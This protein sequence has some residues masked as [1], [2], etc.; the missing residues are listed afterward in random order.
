MLEAT[1]ATIEF[2]STSSQDV[3]TDILR[4]GA[5]RLRVR[6]ARHRRISANLSEISPTRSGS[7]QLI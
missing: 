6:S 3:L 4:D 1:T 7:W 5:Q 2:P